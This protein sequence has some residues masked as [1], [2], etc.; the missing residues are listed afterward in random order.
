MTETEKPSVLSPDEINTFFRELFG[1]RKSM[2]QVISATEGKVS[3]RMA[4]SEKHLRPGGF[5]SGPTQMGLA[6]HAAFVAIFTK[7]GITPMA[8]TSNLN[9][10]F[11]R[12]AKGMALM[13]DAE[14]MKFG[15]AGVV[16]EVTTRTEISE[17]AVSHA[18]V[19]YVMPR[20]D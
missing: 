12:P 3:M 17:K 19:T 11:L 15:R 6:D 7:A 16:V 10:N 18:I 8:L 13:C 14:I 4:C 2:P 1:E 5:I 20:E 9:I